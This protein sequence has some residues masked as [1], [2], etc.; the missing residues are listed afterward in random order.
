VIDGFDPSAFDERLADPA[1]PFVDWDAVGDDNTARL[2]TG[3]GPLDRALGGGWVAGVLNIVVGY[4]HAGKTRLALETIAANPE[5]TALFVSGDESRR[6]IKAS[7]ENVVGEGY[8]ERV[9]AVEDF[10]ADTLHLGQLVGMAEEKLG[11]LD[12]VV[13]DYLEKLDVPG[14]VAPGVESPQG[15]RARAQAIKHLVH[16]H[17]RLWWL[18][19][20]QSNNGGYGRTVTMTD[21]NYGGAPE[22]DGAIVGVGQPPA[23]KERDDEL[24]LISQRKDPRYL[25]VAKNKWGDTLQQPIDAI[26]DKN[27]GGRLRARTTE[28]RRV[29][30]GPIRTDYFK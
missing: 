25:T 21:L 7:L 18:I 30:Q 16:Q 10:E 8:R 6:G 27:N 20:H 17:E 5:T 2:P 19:L 23:G 28:D 22:V 13:F 9:L 12:L 15:G 4:A 14:V 24:L 11:R 29:H 3:I 26:V 1:D